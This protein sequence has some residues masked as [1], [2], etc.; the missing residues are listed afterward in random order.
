MDI[1]IDTLF[2][3]GTS[4]P[5]NGTDGNGIFCTLWE[6]GDAARANVRLPESYVVGADLTL[7]I[8]ESS[9]NASVSHNW[10]V[11]VSVGD[12]SE[13]VASEFISAGPDVITARTIDLTVSGTIGTTALAV[14]DL[15]SIVISRIAAAGSED[16]STVRL[17]S[18]G[19]NLDTASYSSGCLGRLGEIIQIVRADF[20][21]AQQ[22][23]LS[24]S[25]I[26]A[27]INEGMRFIAKEG[28]WKEE[29]SL[30]VSAGETS[31]DLLS[32]ISNLDDVYACRWHDATQGMY[33]CN[34]WSDYLAIK[35]GQALLN[36][37]NPACWIVVSNILYYWPA[38]S[39][40]VTGGIVLLHSYVPDSLDCLSE[41]TPPFPSSHDS[42]L[43][44]YAMSRAHRK[45]VSDPRSA[46]SIADWESMWR[47]GLLDLTRQ[48]LPPASAIYPG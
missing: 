38:S 37:T 9:A 11:Q 2:P 46:N 20:N 4:I 29:A 15:V 44:A 40:D 39:I 31:L 22:A 48:S 8:Q 45:F 24:T 14:G 34:S 10:Q 28:Y 35:T 27:W 41:Y 17:Y 5:A 19:V 3:S 1:R 16:S 25:E 30:D 47:E 7:S 13:T 32:E 6:V 18:Q 42:A 12:D 43:V 23:Y 36:Q 33:L 26:V 21:D